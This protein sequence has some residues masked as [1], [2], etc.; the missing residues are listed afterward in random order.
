[1]AG[2]K[3]KNSFYCTVNILINLIVEMSSQ[4][5]KDTPRL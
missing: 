1:M 4:K 2:S 5:L 3:E